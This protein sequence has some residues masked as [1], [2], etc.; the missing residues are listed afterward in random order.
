MNQKPTDSAHLVT[1]YFHDSQNVAVFALNSAMPSLAIAFQELIG[2]RAC[3]W[4][5]AERGGTNPHDQ[6]HFCRDLKYW[7]PWDDP[8]LRILPTKDSGWFPPL[9]VQVQPGC[10]LE[11][12][13]AACQSPSFPLQRC[14]MDIRS[15]TCCL[16]PESGTV[17]TTASILVIKFSIS[18]N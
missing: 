2:T 1:S 18:K 17:W 11:Y 4:E 13:S 10:Q 12:K 3:M 15:S 6:R 16:A 5:S 8:S 9:V 7:F 14:S